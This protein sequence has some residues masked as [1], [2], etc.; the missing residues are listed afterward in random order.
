[1]PPGERLDGEG[2]SRAGAEPDNHPFLDQL[3]GGLGG[4]AFQSVPL[5][6]GLGGRR[7]HY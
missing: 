7:A 3:H 2:R 5:G 1:M 4:R 6:A